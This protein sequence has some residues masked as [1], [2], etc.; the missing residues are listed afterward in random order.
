MNHIEVEFNENVER[1]SA[2]DI[3]HYTIVE[4]TKALSASIAPDDTLAIVAIALKSDQRTVSITAT[5][6][7]AP[8][9]ITIAGVKDASGNTIQTPV[10]ASFTGTSDP[11]VT[12]PEIA[13]R[14][15]A[16]NATGVATS[17][18]VLIV[19]SEPIFFPSLVAGASWSSS[20]GDV[21]FDADTQD[22]LYIYLIPASPLALGTQY[23]VTLTGVEDLA[24]NVMPIATWSFR[25]SGD[26]DETP[27]TVVSSSPA[28][29]ATQVD[30]TTD[31]SITFSE[32]MDQSYPVE[33]ES[34]PFHD[35]SLGGWTNGGTTWVVDSY[36]SLA[37]Q[38][39]YMLLINPTSARDLAGNP[40]EP[41]AIH[42]TTG[43]ALARGSIAG[44]VA[45]DPQSDTAGDPTGALV[46]AIGDVTEGGGLAVV[47]EG[48]TYD[49]RYLLDDDY[50]LLALLESNGNVDDLD[51]DVGDAFG[52]YGVDLRGGDDEIDIVSIVNGNRVTG[53]NFPLFDPSAI[54]G[55]VEYFGEF[56][57]E[58]HEIRVGL[59]QT[60]GFDP[61]SEP[62]YSTFAF[63]PYD[64][65]WAFVSYDA[66]PSDGTYYL[67]AFLDANDS[68]V[69]EPVID[70]SGFDTENEIVVDNGSDWIGLFI[71]IFDP[72]PGA[73][74]PA[75][76]ASS[77]KVQATQRSELRDLVRRLSDAAQRRRDGN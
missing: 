18:S 8:Y 20:S 23:T 69:F 36:D 24:G 28:D 49:A 47:S 71:T 53:R 11:D 37:T 56:V 51:P 27:P 16:P 39:Q 76:A 13:D 65:E 48:D 61:E 77:W 1:A 40:L 64:P 57:G 42:F 54:T 50:V 43:S 17:T 45:G 67:G 70:P 25:T 21:G 3:A 75:A 6:N 66:G 41:V 63:W 19:F 31:L 22:A 73:T 2:E 72:V 7:P 46:L 9:D 30:V 68:G 14:S 15:P 52:F 44:R 4:T 62:D 12:P 38:Q 34:S 26:P 59:W 55:V 58:P 33:I 35:W 32:P 10:V 5:M 60:V 74:A 29:L